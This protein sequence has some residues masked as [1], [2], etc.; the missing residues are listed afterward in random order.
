MNEKVEGITP[1]PVDINNNGRIDAKEDL[2]DD[3]CSVERALYLGTLPSELCNCIFLIGDKKPQRPEQ[4][5]FVK[6]LLT[7]GQKDV[8]DNGFSRIRNSMANNIIQDLNNNE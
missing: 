4:I 1:L 6:W 7:A 3:L 5:I 2:Y 8:V